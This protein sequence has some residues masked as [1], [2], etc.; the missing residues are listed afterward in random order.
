MERASG[1]I[2]VIYKWPVLGFLVSHHIT[3][4]PNPG[5]SRDCKG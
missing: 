2:K 4:M 3:M 5:L 1:G